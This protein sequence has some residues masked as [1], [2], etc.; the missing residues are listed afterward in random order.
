[1]AIVVLTGES[2]GEMGT[3]AVAAGAQDYL[4]KGNTLDES[5]TRSIRYAVVR[6]HSEDALIRSQQ[7]L[8]EAQRVAR[9]GSWE[10]DLSTNAMTWSVELRRLY[11]YPADASPTFDDLLQRLHPDDH[12]VLAGLYRSAVGARSSFNLDHRI[13]LPDT[14]VRW[15]RSQ[16]RAEHSGTG[17]VSWMHGTAQD[18]TDQKSA[19]GALEHQALHDPLTDLPI[20]RSSSTA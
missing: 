17:P 14:S 13:V 6:K 11:G 3:Q 10:L 18:I 1:M 4:V 5:L 12:D 2:G 9:L 19:E 8:A 20:A 15:I 7:A 16:G